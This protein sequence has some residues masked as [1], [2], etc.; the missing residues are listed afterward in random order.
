M[1]PIRLVVRKPGD[2]EAERILTELAAR[3]GKPFIRPGANGVAHIRLMDSGAHC[4]R[5]TGGRP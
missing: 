3:L 4:S 1:V 2:E 5:R